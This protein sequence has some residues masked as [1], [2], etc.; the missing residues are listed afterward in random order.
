MRLIRPAMEWLVPYLRM[1]EA[2]LP[3]CAEKYILPADPFS[4]RPVGFVPSVWRWAVDGDEVVGVLNV[5]RRLNGALRTWGGHI[6]VAVSATRRRE[7]IGK[8][9]FKRGARM[10]RKIANGAILVTV[11]KANTASLRM[12]SAVAF[13]EGWAFS[14]RLARGGKR[15]IWRIAIR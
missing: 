13:D 1:R 12:V 11:E 3:T 8:W 7:G 9:L 15:E 10:A 5:R 2:T 14:A 6:G 4:E